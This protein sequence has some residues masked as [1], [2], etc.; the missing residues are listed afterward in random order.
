[1]DKPP[2]YQ[3]EPMANEGGLQVQMTQPV[4]GPGTVAITSQPHTVVTIQTVN[5]NVNMPRGIP[6]DWSTPLCGCFED[7]GSCLLGAF[8]PFCYASCVATDMGEPCCTVC[9]AGTLAMRANFRGKHNIQG[10]LI[11]DCCIMTYCGFCGTC[12]IDRE[13]K[14]MKA[15]RAAP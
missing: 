1:M 11:N 9:C 13:L 4:S 14:N 12:Q 2:A 10:S 7:M 15:G 8:F 6:R 5:V 3:Y